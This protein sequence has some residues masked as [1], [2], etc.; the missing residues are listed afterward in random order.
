[1]DKTEADQTKPEPLC[2][3]SRVRRSNRA[4][5]MTR[6]GQAEHATLKLKLDLPCPLSELANGTPHIPVRDMCAWVDRPVES[7]HQEALQ[8]H[9]RIPRPMNSF[10]LYRLAYSDR[11]KY[12][13]AHD[14][15]QA[16][17]ILTGRS[18]KMEPPHIRKQH[19]TL[20]VMEKQKHAEAHP[21]YRFSPS[22]KKKRSRTARP[23]SQE[24]VLRSEAFPKVSRSSQPHAWSTSLNNDRVSGP[25]AE[26]FLAE[27]ETLLKSIPSNPDSFGP[28][29]SAT[30]VWWQGTTYSQMASAEQDST[31]T[32]PCFPV[33]TGQ[34]GIPDSAC[35]VPQS[36]SPGLEAV[37]GQS[38]LLP[39]SVSNET[40]KVDEELLMEGTQRVATVG[41]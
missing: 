2:Q 39:L 23:S 33:V 4:V 18:W 26:P 31:G 17:S 13:L 10:M 37:N 24:F 12:W 40:C 30:S 38:A 16:I 25:S 36:G 3:N 15:H 8:R 14:D 28:L 29:Q 7:R 35:F 9:G 19:K 20:A 22:N 21:E 6:N 27:E 1:M 5:A 32:Q 41:Q 11:A 34:P